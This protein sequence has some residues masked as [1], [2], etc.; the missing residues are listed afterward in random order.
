[1][2]RVRALLA[3]AALMAAP[4]GGLV[5]A[6]RPEPTPPTKLPRKH[7]THKQNARKARKGRK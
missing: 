2:S 1:M 7:S 3:A 4:V 5:W 6:P